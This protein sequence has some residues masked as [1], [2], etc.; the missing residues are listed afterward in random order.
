MNT[1]D[2]IKQIRFLSQALSNNKKL[3]S[4]FKHYTT[5]DAVVKV[6]LYALDSGVMFDQI[7]IYYDDTKVVNSMDSKYENGME[8]Q[9]LTS[10]NVFPSPVSNQLH[11]HCDGVM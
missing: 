8:D 5:S 2:P 1:L 3:L 10:W 11:I 7:L 6:R 4:F 9:N